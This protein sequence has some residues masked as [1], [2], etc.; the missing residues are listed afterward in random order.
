MSNNMMKYTLRNDSQD[1]FI[2]LSTL[3][4]IAK[5]GVAVCT[6]SHLSLYYDIFN[7]LKKKSQYFDVFVEDIPM[8][9]NKK[10]WFQLIEDKKKD[11]KFL[12]KKSYNKNRKI[13]SVLSLIVPPN[14]TTEEF[15]FLRDYLVD[16]G[17]FIIIWMPHNQF[18]KL[19]VGAPDFWRIVSNLTEFKQDEILNYKGCEQIEKSSNLALLIFERGLKINNKNEE[20]L[21]NKGVCLAQM[22]KYDEAIQNFEN[23]LK[24]DQKNSITLSNLS[25]IYYELGQYEKALLLS[26]K[27]LE[28]DIENKNL[29][30]K[31]R[32]AMSMF[33]KKQETL[34]IDEESFLWGDDQVQSKKYIHN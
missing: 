5:T 7:L 28:G 10:Q 21:N 6:Y 31:R 1:K 14:I 4:S 2:E 34:L 27:A 3:M 29:K 15:N 23:A 17:S 19:A 26:D 20:L 13:N 9:N 24:L 32:Q 33:N 25:Q 12:I 30:D 8:T 16:T 22:K 11:W 18:Q